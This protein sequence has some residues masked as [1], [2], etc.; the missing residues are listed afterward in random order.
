MIIPRWNPMTKNQRLRD[1][2]MPIKEKIRLLEKERD[3]IQRMGR[4][5][6][7]HVNHLIAQYREQLG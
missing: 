2:K 1:A 5:V 3:A 6:P 7:M 4:K